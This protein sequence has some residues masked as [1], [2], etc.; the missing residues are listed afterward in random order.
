LSCCWKHHRVL[1]LIV[2]HVLAMMDRI[3]ANG[4]LFPFFYLFSLENYSLTLFV[5]CIWTSV[6]ILLILNFFSWTSYRSF[7]CFQFYP[8]IP[9]CYIYIYIFSIWLLLFFSYFFGRLVEL[10]FFSISLFNQKFI[11]IFYFNF[12]IILLIVFFPLVQ[13]MFLFNFTLQ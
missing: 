1:F 5:I 9:I 6:L 10:I 4:H 13:L 3:V 12:I 11:F 7:I 8:S 2:R